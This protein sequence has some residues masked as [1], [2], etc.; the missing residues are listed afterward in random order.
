M[1]NSR[2]G[3]LLG[4]GKEA[5]VFAYGDGVAKLFRRPGAKA[6]AFREASTMAMVEQTGLPLPRVRGVEQIDDRWAV[7]MDRAAGPPLAERMRDPAAVPEC[8]ERMVL[9]HQ[10]IHAFPATRFTSLKS[11]L[12]GNIERAPALEAALRGRLLDGLAAM[13]G[14]NRL[15]HGDF[16]PMN[17][18]GSAGDEVV[19]DW[20]DAAAGDPAA[21]V[22]RSYVLIR[23]VSPTLADAYADAYA[24]VSGVRR[25][26]IMAWLPYVA[27]ARLAEGVREDVPV[28]LE[29]A[30]TLR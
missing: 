4:I 3:P 10:R 22:C 27:A 30:G 25:S 29:M 11:R 2:L 1:D 12:A 8:I 23:P 5:E 9:L 7:V 21:D 6:A 13:P 15:C 20:I 16:H 18:M 19:L 14:E 17:I 26:A 24:A 28:L